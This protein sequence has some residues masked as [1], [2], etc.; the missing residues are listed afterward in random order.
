MVDRRRGAAR[1]CARTTADRLSAR[2]REKDGEREGKARNHH[3]TDATC[4]TELHRALSPN[5]TAREFRDRDREKRGGEK[6]ESVR[7]KNVKKNMFT[8]LTFLHVYFT[9]CFRKFLGIYVFPGT[10]K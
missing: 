1:C 4:R 10:E 3:A 9:T 2:E 6:A 8:F 7:E 5:T